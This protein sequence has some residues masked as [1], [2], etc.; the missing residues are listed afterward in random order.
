MWHPGLVQP[1][2]IPHG[3]WI[4]HSLQVLSLWKSKRINLCSLHVATWP[5]FLFSVRRQQ[6]EKMRQAGRFLF[7]S[8]PSRSSLSFGLVRPTGSCVRAT[9][10]VGSTSFP[11][12]EMTKSTPADPEEGDWTWGSPGLSRCPR[13][14]QS[15]CYS[16][17]ST[18]SLPRASYKLSTTQ[19]LTWSCVEQSAPGL[20]AKGAEL[21][22]G[23]NDI[24]P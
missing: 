24:I 13:G 4:L 17:F 1:K 12:T 20:A 18:P 8:N 3:D 2:T 11:P 7:L 22:R 23:Q 10:M 5:G 6:G 19:L 21:L 16:S 14:K 9:V 15:S